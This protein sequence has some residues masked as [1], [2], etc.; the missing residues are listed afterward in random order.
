GWRR[1]QR[2]PQRPPAGEEPWMW[3]AAEPIGTA[4]ALALL[5]AGEIE[6]AGRVREAS[7]LVLWCTIKP[8]GAQVDAEDE[9]TAPFHVAYK[10]IRGERPLDDFPSGTLAA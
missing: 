1:D 3:A 9:A 2:V 10:P 8:A 7:N 5:R 4:D 6:V